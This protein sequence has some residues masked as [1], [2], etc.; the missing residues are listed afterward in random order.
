MPQAISRVERKEM[1]NAV[2]HDGSTST[3]EFEM[4]QWRWSRNQG[5]GQT[6]GDQSSSPSWARLPSQCS[7]FRFALPQNQENIFLMHRKAMRLNSLNIQDALWGPEEAQLG[8]QTPSSPSVGWNHSSRDRGKNSTAGN[9][10]REIK[11]KKVWREQVSKPVK[12]IRCR[13]C[14]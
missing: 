14:A 9:Q 2:W 12:N 11:P 10:L 6:R 13:K 5:T 1:K 8:Q 7:A 4:K 3:D